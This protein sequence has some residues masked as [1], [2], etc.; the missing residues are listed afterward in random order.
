[1][2]GG[3]VKVSSVLVKKFLTIFFVTLGVVFFILIL[4]AVY[5]FVFDPLHLKPVL[6]GSTATT[7]LH[8]NSGSAKTDLHP[9][10][11]ETQEKTLET[12]G[13][14]PRDV[15]SEITPSQ[16]KCF[17]DKLGKARV[18]EIKAGDSPTAVEFFTA[19]ECI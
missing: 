10:L 17:E 9:L 3:C 8:E 11:S 16:E 19:K 5:L 1:M 12:F 4:G 18:E 7:Q 14:D 2:L 6:F 13:I 15:P